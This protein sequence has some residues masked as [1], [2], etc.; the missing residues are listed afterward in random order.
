M[1]THAFKKPKVQNKH[2]NAP[3]TQIHPRVPPSGGKS[4][5]V[6]VTTR[7]LLSER[8]ASLIVST[9]L[10][11]ALLLVLPEDITTLMGEAVENCKLVFSLKPSSRL[12]CKSRGLSFYKMQWISGTDFF[13]GVGDPFSPTL[14]GRPTR[15]TKYPMRLDGL[16]EAPQAADRIEKKTSPDRHDLTW[17]DPF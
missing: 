9:S 3:A 17:T 11:E 12:I 6:G 14:H 1:H 10:L 8:S 15:F 13:E 5:M 2:M 16:K 7:S 4:G